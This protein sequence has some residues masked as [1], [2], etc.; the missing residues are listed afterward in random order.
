MNTVPI[1]AELCSQNDSDRKLGQISETKEESNDMN[2]VNLTGGSD[3][4]RGKTERIHKDAQS[5]VRDKEKTKEVIVGG[6]VPDKSPKTPVQGK[7]DF[8]QASQVATVE[9]QTGLAGEPEG[10]DW[11]NSGKFPD[12][13]SRI[14][15]MR[16]DVLGMSSTFLSQFG[17]E[18]IFG[19]PLQVPSS[20]N[21]VQEGGMTT[22]QPGEDNA[23]SVAGGAKVLEKQETEAL[24]QSVQKQVHSLSNLLN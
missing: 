16:K 20:L 24:R 14:D 19:G 2:N 9:K 7:N 3:G 13:E 12:L 5:N 10:D 21:N 11:M 23:H 18:R 8:M 4:M 17:E 1:L 15:K 22:S 6:K